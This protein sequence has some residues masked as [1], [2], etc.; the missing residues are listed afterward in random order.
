MTADGAFDTRKCHDAIAA[1]RAI[2]II[3][4]RKSATPW[5]PDT[6]GLIARVETLRPDDLVTI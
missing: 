6:P 5:K 3:P 4:P 2:A 1:R